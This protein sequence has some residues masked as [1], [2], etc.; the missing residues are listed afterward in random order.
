MNGCVNMCTCQMPTEI[1][2]VM[3]PSKKRHVEILYFFDK[4]KA[5]ARV[6]LI[7]A[8]LLKDQYGIPE[9][10]VYVETRQIQDDGRLFCG[11]V[12]SKK[13]V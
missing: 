11:T 8:S 4:A 1:H 3:R 12:K 2:I 9:P 6:L 7:N 10:H 13:P 5:D